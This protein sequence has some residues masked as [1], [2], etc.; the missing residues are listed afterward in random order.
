MSGTEKLADAL[1][2]RAL[3]LRQGDWS[4]GAADAALMGRAADA[5]EKLEPHSNQL[6]PSRWYQLFGT[7]ERAARTLIDCDAFKDCAC[8]PICHDEYGDTCEIPGDDCALVMRN[9]DALLEW[10]EGDA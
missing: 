9:Y 3:V 6:E 8:C 2:G 10:L 4:D 1:R 5:I 7:P